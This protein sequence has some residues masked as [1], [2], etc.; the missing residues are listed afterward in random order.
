MIKNDDNKYHF[1]IIDYIFR[2]KQKIENL[3]ILFHAE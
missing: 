2:E 3:N 1:R